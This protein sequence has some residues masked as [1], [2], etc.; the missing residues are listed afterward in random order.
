MTRLKALETGFR[1]KTT[2]APKMSINKEKTQ[3]RASCIK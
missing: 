1:R 3:K 2:A